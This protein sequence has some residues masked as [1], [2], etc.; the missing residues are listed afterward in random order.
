MVS[1]MR[2]SD[3]EVVLGRTRARRWWVEGRRIRSLP[4][5][6]KFIDDVGFAL[7]FPD[8][9]VILPALWDAVAD[10]DA[11]P[12]A[13]GMGQCEGLVWAWKDELPRRGHAWYGKFIRG[14]ASLLSPAMLAALYPGRGEARDH[15]RLD[16]SP[17]AHRIAEALRLGPMSSTALRAA[18]GSRSGYAR[19]IGELHRQLVV[20]AAG[21]DQTG[22][23]W[24]A[25]MLD[26]T[27]R[28]FP[29]GGTRDSAYATARFLDTM[30]KATPT[31][32]ARV[33]GWPL[34]EARAQFAA[35]A[36]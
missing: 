11:E 15:E 26:L 12:F 33:F 35:A 36:G 23:G 3:A 25:T 1:G 14:R 30:I 9:H 2:A 17:A 7:L 34:A 31:D 28:R 13:A 21:V 18:V 27:C 32:L 16:L 19:A 8:P 5:A 24:P 29:V 22:A 4:R 6:A 10:A 20:T